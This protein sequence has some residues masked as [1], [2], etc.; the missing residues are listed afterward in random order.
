MINSYRNENFDNA[1][2]QLWTQVADQEVGADIHD[3]LG[4]KGY[5]STCD[6][7][8]AVYWRL[9]MEKYPKAKLVLIYR[10]PIQWYTSFINTIANMQPDNP[11][12]PFGVRVAFAMGLPCKGTI[13]IIH[14]TFGC[15][16][17]YCF[18]TIFRSCRDVT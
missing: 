11:L 10:D 2:A 12:C 13:A 1:H 8:S 3:I 7:P 18:L 5:R 4:K 6:F 16:F 14:D 15:H 9:Q 17:F